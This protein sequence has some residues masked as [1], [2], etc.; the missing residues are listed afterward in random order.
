M[1]IVSLAADSASERRFGTMAVAAVEAAGEAA[2]A[3][4]AAAAA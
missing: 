4:E 3:A 2:E 1:P